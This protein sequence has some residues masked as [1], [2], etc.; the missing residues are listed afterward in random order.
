[1]LQIKETKKEFGRFMEAKI[2]K[3]ALCEQFFLKKLYIF[4]LV[5]FDPC[6]FNFLQ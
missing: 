1:M 6:I 4:L 2:F 3:K 5:N